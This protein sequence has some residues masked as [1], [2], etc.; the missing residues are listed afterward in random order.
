M[1][2]PRFTAA[3]FYTVFKNRRW[4]LT[5]YAIVALI[6]AILCLFPRPYV[7]RAKLLPQDS[8]SA[9][10]GQLIN[11]L[12]G[13]LSNFANLLGGGRPPNDL[14]LVI[15]RS[16]AVRGDVIDTLKLAGP[17]RPY[18]TVD[19]AKI[20][21]DKAVEVR[22]LLGGVVEVE[23]NTRN[24]EKSLQ[25]TQ[26]YVQ[27]ISTRIAGM[28]RQTITRKTEIVRQR[29]GEAAARVQQTET[30]LNTFRK[31]NRLADPEV[32]LGTEISLRTQLQAKL[33]AKTVELQTVQQFSGPENPQLRS[34]Q[35][36]I[37]ALRAQLAQAEKPAVGAAGPNVS[38][39]SEIASQY[40][41]LY[42]DY[43]FAQSLYEVY[44]R[45][46]EQVA[47]E[48]LV[49]ES[50]TYIQVVEPTHLDPERHYNVSAVALLIALLALALFTEI[51]A[52]A[53]G[54][55]WPTLSAQQDS[56]N[57]D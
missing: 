7:A 22:L 41:N 35:S 52:P 23:T 11:A 33:Q 25:L 43:R 4:R 45:S 55:R 21:L 36:E 50:A 14:Y 32:Q 49:A 38:G 19:A 12:G 1:T 39:L 40:L 27:A 30:A 53:T 28:T 16:D 26:A 3:P 2:A 24:P 46:A 13:Q 37:A 57:D 9:G 42:R 20:A 44:S 17:S 10:L 15:G 51:Y 18:A 8:S 47:V 56:R 48:G 34:I 54:L 6:L 31:Q 5:A 29:F